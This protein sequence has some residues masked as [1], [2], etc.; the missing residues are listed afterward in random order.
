MH[1]VRKLSRLRSTQLGAKLAHVAVRLQGLQQEVEQ[2]LPVGS[3]AAY[4]D[5]HHVGRD[6]AD[7]LRQLS[8]IEKELATAVHER[9]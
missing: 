8:S 2:G 9:G 4:A 5:T 1:A 3:C 6:L 7:M